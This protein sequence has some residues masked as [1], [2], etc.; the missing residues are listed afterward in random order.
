MLLN[1]PA[2]APQGQARSNTQ[3][4]RDLAAHM[5]FTE[6]C[7]A[8][9]DEQLCRQAYGTQVDFAQLLAQGF[10]P[11]GAPEAPF[12]EGGFPTPSG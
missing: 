4:F 6:P 2:I 12:A 1:R 7:F 9:D 10:A 5:G 3:I 11:A 8:E